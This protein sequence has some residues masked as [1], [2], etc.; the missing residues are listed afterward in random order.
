MGKMIGW[1]LAGW[2]RGY[3]RVGQGSG[4]ATVPYSNG[5][6]VQYRTAQYGTGPQSRQLPYRRTGHG[7]FVGRATQSKLGWQGAKSPEYIR[8][9]GDGRAGYRTVPVCKWEEERGGRKASFA[10][11]PIR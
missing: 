2:L 5:R 6:Q 1:W 10:V 9:Y 8:W 11:A 3:G 7:R 4:A